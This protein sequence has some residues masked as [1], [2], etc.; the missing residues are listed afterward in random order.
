MCNVSKIT[1]GIIPNR[2]V[3]IIKNNN[4]LDIYHTINI[5]ILNN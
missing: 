1:L 4:K 5:K 2:K 3:G